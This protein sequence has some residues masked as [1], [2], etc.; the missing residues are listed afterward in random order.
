MSNRENNTTQ[1]V[2]EVNALIKKSRET[3][4]RI[5]S[6]LKMSREYNGT[7]GTIGGSTGKHMNGQKIIK[8]DGMSNVEHIDFSKVDRLLNSELTGADTGSGSVYR[9][10][11]AS[12]TYKANRY[13]NNAP[14]DALRKADQVLNMF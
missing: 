8:I 11:N 9:R 7:G 4:K 13:G 12:V 3:R 2:N 5:S 10:H 6:A 14:E 1:L